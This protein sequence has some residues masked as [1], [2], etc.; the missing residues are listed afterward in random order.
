MGDVTTMTTSFR[1][2]TL[3]RLLESFEDHLQEAPQAQPEIARHIKTQLQRAASDEALK[4]D[5]VEAFERLQQIA[6][7]DSTSDSASQIARDLGLTEPFLTFHLRIMRRDRDMLKATPIDVKAI[8][9][10]ITK[11]PAT[12]YQGT[13]EVEQIYGKDYAD[14]RSNRTGD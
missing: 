1:K 12:P 5:I 11:S 13:S 10:S 6:I 2:P 3:K 9:S 8:A 7:A 4:V 14:G